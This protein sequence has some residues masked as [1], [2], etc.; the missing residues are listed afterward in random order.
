VLSEIPKPIAH[1]AMDGNPIDFQ[2]ENS[3]TLSVKSNMRKLGKVPP[4]NIGQP[5]ASTFWSSFPHLAPAGENVNSLTYEQSA[6]VFKQVAQAEIVELL[7]EYWRNLFLCDYTIYV[8][9]VLGKYNKLS[10]QPKV[11]VFKKTPSPDW[12]RSSISFTQSVATWNESCTVKYGNISIGVFQIHK[13]RN[14]F[15]FRFNLPGLIQAG[16][17]EIV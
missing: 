11:K 12:Q 13:K 3:A 17:L 2:L 16:L 10:S 6:Q 14:C 5:T 9:E 1:T 8:F 15:K 4:Q 7:G